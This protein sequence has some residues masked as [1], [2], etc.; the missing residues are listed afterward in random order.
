MKVIA[1]GNRKHPKKHDY[2]KLE[3]IHLPFFIDICILVL[4]WTKPKKNRR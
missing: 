4:E 2:S 3:E 1:A